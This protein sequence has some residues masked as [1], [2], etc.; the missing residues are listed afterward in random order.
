[1]VIVH[2]LDLSGGEL[3]V[4]L[5]FHHNSVRRKIA[6]SAREGLI[7][8]EGATPVLL[9]KFYRLLL[10]KRGR[11]RLPPQP[12]GWLDK[13]VPGFGEQLKIRVVSK[14]AVPI[15]SIMTISCKQVM[16]YK[17]GCSDA[18]F[19]AL[20]GTVHLLWR[21][22]QDAVSSG[23]SEFDFGRSDYGNDGLI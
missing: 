20:G 16:T 9:R 12:L 14:D 4:F 13:L 19:N 7:Y 21:A 8:E 2:K 23:A 10:L 6:R 1:D 18:N 17:Y 15:A 3:N 11:A 22:I 5:N